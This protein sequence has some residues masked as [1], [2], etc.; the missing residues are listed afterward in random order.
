LV[1][2]LVDKEFTNPQITNLQPANLNYSTHQFELYIRKPPQKIGG[3][4]DVD[5]RNVDYWLVYWWILIC[6]S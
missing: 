3:L 6:Q 5:W 2:G 1:G 4:V